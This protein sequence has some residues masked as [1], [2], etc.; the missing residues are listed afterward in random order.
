MPDPWKPKCL[1][2]IPRAQAS[3]SWHGD[4]LWTEASPSRGSWVY[5]TQQGNKFH[6]SMKPKLRFTRIFLRVMGAVKNW[7]EVIGSQT[8]EGSLFH[9]RLPARAPGLQLS[10]AITHVPLGFSVIGCFEPPTHDI[11]VNNPQRKLTGSSSSI[12]LQVFL[13]SI[14]ASQP[15]VNRY[16]SSPQVMT[17]S[18]YCQLSLRSVFFPETLQSAMPC[19]VEGMRGEVQGLTRAMLATLRLARVP[20]VGPCIKNKQARVGGRWRMNRTIQIPHGFK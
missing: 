4:F 15:G 2:T 16:M 9:A 6:M 3:D 14:S 8:E 18:Q 19:K 7:R 5:E 10:S 1:T 11:S 17:I 12:W 13:W 20:S